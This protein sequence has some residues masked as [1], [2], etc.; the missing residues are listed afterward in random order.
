[1]GGSAQL[2]HG[3]MVV[4]KI[5]SSSFCSSLGLL[6]FKFFIFHL[7]K[8]QLFRI[9]CRIVVTSPWCA[10]HMSNIAYKK[11]LPC[12]KLTSK[13]LA[14][15]LKLLHPLKLPWTLAHLSVLRVQEDITVLPS[16][17][18]LIVKSKLQSPKILL[19][20]TTN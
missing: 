5:S 2:F 10:L 15:I 11:Y 18:S 4:C 16:R 12:F 19:T 13:H 7:N 14:I 3:W 20:Y 17:Q 8:C 1:M 9:T 6:H